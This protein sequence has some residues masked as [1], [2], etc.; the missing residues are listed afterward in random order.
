VKLCVIGPTY[1]YRGGISH[2]T[3]FL[4]QHLRNA[5]HWAQLYSYIRQY[6]RWLFP[7]RT[8]QDPSAEPLKVECKYILDPINPATWLQVARQVRADAPDAL[9]LQWWVPYWAP[10]LAVISRWIRRNTAIR[11]VFI[12]HNV[13]PH[14]GGGALDHRLAKIALGQG[15]VFIV[16]SDQEAQQLKALLPHAVVFKAHFPTYAGLAHQS[17][18][19]AATRLRRELKLPD[20]QPVV[21]FFG[22]VRPYKGLDYLVRALPLVRKKLP[23]HLVV[24]GEFWVPPEAYH[25][26]ACDLGVENAITFVNRYI[27]NEEL[28]LYFDLADVVVLPYV[29]AT[30]SAAIPLAFGFG[31]P[32]ITTRVGGLHEVVEDGVTGLIVPPQDEQALADAIIYFYT[33]GLGPHL[34]ANVR[35]RQAEGRFGWD[36]LIRL[37]EQAVQSMS[38]TS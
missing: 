3:T 10:S 37:I 17:D 28:G 26:L 33:Q 24:V 30:Q 12:V 27:P 21:L 31:K 6:P 38:S 32:V 36:A 14:E 20:S 25:R 9:I 15:D 7:G 2:Y 18:S 22:F 19:G 29:S 35:C 8:D 5:G 23:V 11:V 16:H 1:P 4:V 34:A 13:L